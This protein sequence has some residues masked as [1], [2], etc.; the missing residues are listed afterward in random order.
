MKNRYFYFF[1]SHWIETRTKWEGLQQLAKKQYSRTV[2]RRL[3]WIIYYQTRAKKNARLTCRYFGISPKTFYK[4]LK[5]F[6]DRNLLTLENQS[7]APHRRR[8]RETSIK[9]EH[10]IIKFRKK[11]IRWGKKKLKIIYKQEYGENISEWKI[12]KTIEKYKLYYDKKKTAKIRRKRL[13]GQKKKRITELRKKH[14]GGFLIQIDTI[15]KY[16]NGLKFYIITAID[17]VTKIAF[18][19]MYRSHSS[20]TS[21]DFLYRLAYILDY[22]IEN[23]QTDNG[24]EFAKDFDRACVKLDY[25]H[26]YS[27]TKTPKD[28]SMVER[29]NRTL[30]EEFIQL[31]NFT[32]SLKE[33]NKTLTEWLVEYNFK[34]PHQ[35]LD[36][37]TP[38]SYSQ[39]Y[40]NL[41]PML[42][43][44]TNP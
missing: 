33:F 14:K 17:V 18:A 29:F 31:G 7:R 21:A 25:S 6:E 24:S 40:F 37:L 2:V 5:R 11:Y 1:K 9:Q 43:S 16:W 19:R 30:K 4:W 34:R 10:R 13:R 27:R 32:P 12:Q 36:F 42:S 28:N 35:S 15:V 26:Y 8:Q 23:I 3:E 38:I 20:Y 22:K 41:L 39:K 44:R